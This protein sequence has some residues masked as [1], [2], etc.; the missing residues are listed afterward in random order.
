[1]E[2][3]RL[4]TT[5]LLCCAVTFG[6]APPAGKVFPLAYDQHDF[7]NGLRLVTIPTDYPNVV[8][9]YIVVNTGS[10]NE[11]E[12]GKSGFAHLFEHMM[13]RG[14]KTFPQERYAAAM[15]NFGAA[16][17]AYTSTDLTVYHVTFSK[18]DLAR[19]LEMEAD[20]FQHLEYSPDVFKTE[21]LA[22]LGE[23]NK[24]SASPVSKLSE[25]LQKTAYDRH[26]YR[27][28][29][30]GFLEDIKNMPN[31]YDYSREFFHRYYRPE[32]VTIV[33]A[34][35]VTVPATVDLVGKYFS[36]WEHGSYKPDIPAEPPQTAPRRSHVDW[37]TPTLP[38][39]AV[40][41]HVPAYSD[42]S[43]DVAALELI[44]HLGFGPNSELY[45]RLVMQE[46]KLDLFGADMPFAKD[47]TLFE[48]DARLKNPADLAA[49]EQR[50]LETLEQFKT[51]PVPVEQLEK[52][53][54]NLRYSLALR[55]DNSESIAATVSRNLALVRTP[56]A[57][58]RFYDTLA[59]VT[60]ADIQ[61]TAR[62]YFVAT[63]RTT[64]TL[65]GS[66]PAGGNQK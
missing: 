29:T 22:V 27:H 35:D 30:M 65:T 57:I 23:Y 11:I 64:I 10:R 59:A 66:K 9:L 34:G 17:N 15:K 46:Q 37:A 56:E 1:V 51:T 2:V 39:L 43:K 63:G 53:K 38:W 31:L 14:T 49:V 8:A 21:T 40:A 47:P 16:Q 55:M 28:T 52:V 7:A 60:P 62:K 33:V 26:T 3:I 48:V 36:A 25:E 58:N 5:F 6:A 32:Y 13:F 18:E 20:R 54:S 42:T 44:S 19:V 61:A 4:I 12:P 24:N 41:F 45:R 50:V